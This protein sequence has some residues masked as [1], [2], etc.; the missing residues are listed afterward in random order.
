[1]EISKTL[2]LEL[3]DAVVVLS[4]DGLMHEIFNGFAEHEKP[5]KAFGTPI[6]PVPTGSA[7]GTA[8]NLFGRKASAIAC[9]LCVNVLMGRLCRK[10]L[11]LELRL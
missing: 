10:G 1:M 7:N 8:I 5:E 6:A 2:P 4:G 11:T 3:F 9:T